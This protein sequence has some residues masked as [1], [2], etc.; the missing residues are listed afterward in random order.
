MPVVWVVSAFIAFTWV[1]A[2]PGLHWT[3][4]ALAV[5]ALLI[6]SIRSRRTVAD[7]V[8]V[9]VGVALLSTPVITD[10]QPVIV[11]CFLAAL[12]VFTVAAF[13]APNW[14][15]TL[16]APVAL[17]SAWILSLSWWNRSRPR[18]SGRVRL[19]W[20]WVRGALIAIALVVFFSVLLGSAD[21]RFAGIL[22]S[23]ASVWDMDRVWLS[24]VAFVPTVGL[25]A[26]WLFA[27]RS[28]PR[29][30]RMSPSPRRMPP[31]VW[32]LPLAAVDLVLLVFGALQWD[33]MFGRY[34]QQ[35][36]ESDLS[37][38]D[39]VHHGFW[40][41]VVVT[42]STLVLL[43]W[44]GWRAD[45][46]RPRHRRILMATGGALVLLALGVVAS[47]LRRLW[48]Y[49]QAYGWTVLRLE[50]GVFEIWLGVVLIAVAVVWLIGR[51]PS[52]SRLVVLSAATVLVLLTV[53]R[54][55]ALVARWNIDRL[56]DTGKVDVEYLSTLSADA[57][58]ELV[59]LPEPYRTQAL[60]GR[61][62]GGDPVF[63]V[64]LSRVR[65][66][67]ALADVSNGNPCP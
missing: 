15:G 42:L 39:R 55:E 67:A 17:V 30:E 1:R 22:G 62:I 61:E 3:L 23:V 44:A 46:D 14:A 45:R 13:S 36:L 31:A 56:Q 66:R 19:D 40:Q 41:L 2:L 64:S 27:A 21:P 34:D 20:T 25:L 24:A 35:M 53:A 28:A 37:Y 5:G 43:A 51:G 6:G 9:V 7:L 16:L 8:A 4:A 48:L 57:V 65:A 38:A 58:P 18:F 60:D 11:L 49:E 12:G 52:V 47:A 50:V 29:W 32:A 26:T 33:L 59:C 63:A 10:N 54:P